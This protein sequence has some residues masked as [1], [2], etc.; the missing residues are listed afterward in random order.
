M[1]NKGLSIFTLAMINVAAVVSLRGLPAEAEYGLSSIFY[2]IFAA[3]CFLV[4]V[5]L[6][7]A[8]MA[9][10][11]PQKGGVFRWVGEAFSPKMGFLAIWLQ[12]VQNSIWFPT[13]LT[14]AAVSLAF[15]GPDDSKDL[16]LS[17]NK[18]YT[19]AIVL[20]V[21]WLATFANFMGVKVAGVI[22]KWGAMLGTLIPGGILIIMGIGY[23]LCGGEIQMPLH[24][25]DLI[26]DL[27][28]F[29][30]L[31]LAVSIFLFYAGMEMSA[32]H[33]TE[34][35]NPQKNY[36]KAIFLASVITVALF[37]LGTLALGFIIPQAQINLTQSLLV[38]YND[39]FAFFGMPCLG[40]GM[41]FF[42]A[43]G[44]FA[45]VSTWVA[46][47]S[48]GLLVVGKAG[49]LPKWFQKTNKEG[50]QVNI[51]WLQAIIVT[52]LSVFFVLL[53]SV[54]S[55]YQ[56]LSALTVA[57]Y[58]V[59]YILMFVAYLKLKK[60]KPNVKRSFEAPAGCFWG[61]L[62]LIAS[63]MALILNY[64]PPAQIS[65]GNPKVWV[66]LLLLGTLLGIVIPF[67]IYAC[68]KDEW[69]DKDSD[70]EPFSYQ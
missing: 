5:S 17:S 63:V 1:K 62:G 3:V 37:V 60:T 41:A 28:N 51:L 16:V 42:L 19:L 43:I 44:V 46:G 57:L 68:R 24:S 18:Y 34:V 56:I 7:S 14:F 50:I 67:A 39:F 32:V 4:P 59:M 30:N 9:T 27:T 26:P 65:V 38:G 8:E 2:Y 6:V 13:V 69:K 20:G 47:P 33:I 12:W 55:A 11:W 54:Q 64:F 35:E 49:Y 70:V 53:P 45:G 15:I 40:Q 52:I 21:Y 25:S 36:P 58:L 48:K 61:T 31:A 10:G 66:G 23:A 29:N 22:S